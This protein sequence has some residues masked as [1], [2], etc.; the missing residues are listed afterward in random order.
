MK[1]T[2]LLCFEGSILKGYDINSGSINWQYQL[3]SDIKM[4]MYSN[5]ERNI[6]VLYKN[7]NLTWNNSTGTQI[8]T[9]TSGVDWFQFPIGDNNLI[10][11][12]RKNG[13][14]NLINQRG[15]NLLNIYN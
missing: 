5:T 9:I 6:V 10:F 11:V 13:T 3:Y 8:N 2:K 4:A 7:G 1:R 15:T 12:K 14:K